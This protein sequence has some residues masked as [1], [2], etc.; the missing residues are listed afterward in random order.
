MS[1]L[2]N[3]LTFYKKHHLEFI[4]LIGQLTNRK[5][6]E[7]LGGGYYNPIFPLLFPQD[8]SGQIELLTSE[9]RQSIGKRP[10]GMMLYGSVWEPSLIPC[11]QTCGMEYV[12]I[13]S[14]LIP[15]G[16]QNYLPIIMA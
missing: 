16:K 9:L 6:L 13:D 10:R 5:Q 12:F 15:S 7:I 11:L 4:D 2:G 1:F 14:S 8:R 3:Q